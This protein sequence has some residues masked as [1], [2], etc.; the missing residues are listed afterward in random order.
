[1][2]ATTVKK[3]TGKLTWYL[4]S[5]A[6]PGLIVCGVK[7]T[8][9]QRI[10]SLGRVL[11]TEPP[12][13]RIFRLTACQN[14]LKFINFSF[15]Y[16]FLPCSFSFSFFLSFL[17][18]RREGA[19]LPFLQCRTCL[20]LLD[21]KSNKILYKL[22]NLLKSQSTLNGNNFTAQPVTNYAGWKSYSFSI[23]LTRILDHDQFN[24]PPL[25]PTDWICQGTGCNIAFSDQLSAVSFAYLFQFSVIY[26]EETINAKIIWYTNLSNLLKRK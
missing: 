15:L 26:Y 3:F 16:C 2:C 18:S 5:G 17:F 23:K 12:W 8:G 25:A 6:V 10:K 20:L 14:Q 7:N 21:S 19:P 9:V 11:G 24:H 13:W 4:L 1:M 22:L